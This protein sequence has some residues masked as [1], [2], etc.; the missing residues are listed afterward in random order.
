MFFLF[1]LLM[2]ARFFRRRRTP[3]PRRVWWPLIREDRR[4]LD[5]LG[6]LAPLVSEPEG[7]GWI[8][9]SES[10]EALEYLRS[11]VKL[12]Q[13]VLSE[14]SPLTSLAPTDWPNQVCVDELVLLAGAGDY[15]FF[16]L[17]YAD[18]EVVEAIAFGHLG[19]RH[20][21]TPIDLD[22]LLSE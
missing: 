10:V 3:L 13:R 8:T 15:A 21:W 19:P 2:L 6:V 1:R 7:W 4:V 22:A 5:R 9:V 18:G 16:A 12:M 20:P 14:T 11:F 17:R